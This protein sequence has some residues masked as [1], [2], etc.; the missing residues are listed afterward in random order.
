ML[1][2]ATALL[3]ATAALAA[4][5]APASADSIAYVK[6]GDVFLATPD[7]ARQQQVTK[8]GDYQYVSQ[9][10]DGTMAALGPN[11]KIRKLDR[12]G[13]V[14]A[15]FPTYVSDGAP[16]AGPVNQFAGPYN[17]EISPDGSKIA[18]EWYNNSYSNGGSN[19]NSS[20]VPPCYVLSS[21][22]GVGITHSDRFTGFEEFGLL[23][24]WLGP[25]WMSNDRL[26]RS[27]VYVSPNVDAVINDIAPGQGDNV[28]KKWFWDD[29]GAR[30]VEEV[31]I[32]RD[33]KVAAGIAGDSNQLRVYRVL[34][35]PMTAPE[36]KLGPFDKNPQVVEPCFAGDDPVGGKIENLSFAPDGKH[37]AYT[38]GDGVWIMDIPDLSGGC[39]EVPTTNKLVIPGARHP[40]WGPADIPPASAYER[41]NED[42]KPGPTPAPN[43]TPAPQPETGKLVLTVAGK[44]KLRGALARGAT[45][46]V[47]APGAGTVAATGKVGAKRVAS[48]KK[49]VAAPGAVTL[50]LKFTKGAKRALKRKRSVRVNVAVT[51]T[52][53][54]GGAAQRQAAVLRLTR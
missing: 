13:N 54:A 11:E 16:Q 20:S 14:I 43:P 27:N 53:A 1:K 5:A 7:G 45:I 39:G 40:H 47:Q 49:A 30:G 17:P 50:K 15:E 33:Q 4:A 21:R 42:V 52:P 24:G 9:A 46:T 26:L 41:R 31:E 23:T 19:C 32:T 34:Y 18:F 51:F 29:N 37:L 25:H 44:A 12:L 38:V 35:D 3:A 2:T 10:D 28:M 48:A 6:D 36:Q 22:T 8:T